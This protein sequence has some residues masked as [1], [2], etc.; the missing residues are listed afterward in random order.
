M[1][2]TNTIRPKPIVLVILDGWGVAP[3]SASNAITLAKMPTYNALVKNYPAM[4]LQAS[5]ES[6]GLSWG[7][8]GNSEVGHL[9]IGSGKLIYQNLPKIDKDITTG[10]FFSNEK[11]LTAINTAKRKKKSLHLMGLL[12]TGGVHASLNHLYALLELCH[13]EKFKNVFIHAFLDGRDMPYN[14]GLDLIAK[15]QEKIKEVKIGQIASI[16]GRFYAMDRDN[17]WER[18]AL[19][20]QAIANGQSADRFNDPLKAVS[21]SY[22]KKIYD[23]ELAPVV[24][25]NKDGPLATVSEGDSLIFFNFRSDRA[26]Q[27][28]K[29]FVLPGFE[30]FERKYLPD[31]YFVTMTE[32]EKDLPVEIA[33]PLDVINQPLAKVISEAGLKQLHIA[34][35]EKYAHVTFFLNGGQE[36]TFAGEDRLLIPSPRV[37]T[38]DKKPEMSA[39]E[40]TK[41]L[42]EVIIKNEYDFIVVNYANSD[43]VAHTGNL[44]ASIRACEAIDSSLKQLIEIILAKNG[45]AF[46]TSDHGNA[47]E[48]LNLQSGKID[49]EHSTY[50]VP[51]IIVGRD[52]AG[53]TAGLPEGPNSDLSLVQPSGLLSD[54]APTILKIMSIEKPQ[55]MTGQSLI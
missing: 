19:A 41:K 30:K 13:K 27:L 16:N 47:E 45:L 14:S 28:T 29:A 6:V 5:G 12:T 25:I 20:Y 53:K 26:R 15:V 17:H 34:E 39:K 9:N 21:V 38:Y 43:M 52:W 7:E 37:A 40:I 55:E 31:L 35:T 46:I 36:E 22:D 18:I 2:V 1:A 10:S 54:I 8:I 51:F 32:Y 3:A 44:K 33:F 11:L 4:T 50:P 49:K 42:M 23:E 48:L 24:I